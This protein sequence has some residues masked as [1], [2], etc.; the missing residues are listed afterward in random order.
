MH[1]RTDIEEFSGAVMALVNLIRRGQARAFDTEL[2][3]VMQLLADGRA[4][5]PSEIA[6][7]LS[8]PRP[9]VTRRIQALEAAGKIEIH[10]DPDDR[11]SYRVA[12]SA[13]GQAELDDLAAKG[14]KL[15]ATWVSAWTPAEVRTF[16]ALARRL[17][18]G[19]V[20]PPAPARG[21]AWWREQQA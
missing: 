3:A 8:S 10:P 17:T 11:R 5:P 20:T 1:E 16:S 6:E 19:A 7:A 2:V 13:A 15:F 14:M 9:S 12:L 21:N 4:L 18:D